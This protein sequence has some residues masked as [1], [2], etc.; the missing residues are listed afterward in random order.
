MAQHTILAGGRS[1]DEDLAAR[2]C[3][4]P[5]IVVRQIEPP[6]RS[7]A[8]HSDGES[9]NEDGRSHKAA[10][11]KEAIRSHDRVLPHRTRARHPG[12]RNNVVQTSHSRAYTN[13]AAAAT[14]W[15]GAGGSAADLP[16]TRMS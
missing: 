4:L 15:V 1:A 16:S 12:V 3:Q 14:G 2:L 11:V 13:H 6:K 5:V 9:W 8:I 7:A 10:K